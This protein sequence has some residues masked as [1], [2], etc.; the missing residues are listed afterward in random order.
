MFYRCLLITAALL[1]TLTLPAAASAGTHPDSRHASE[2]TE[3]LALQSADAYWSQRGRAA[4]PHPRIEYTSL[5]NRASA[6]AFVGPNLAAAYCV[7]RM[8]SRHTWRG[9]A[10]ALDFCWTIVHERGHQAGLEHASSGIMS[11]DGGDRPP[12]ACTRLFAKR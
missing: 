12:A 5:A 9:R 4:C 11:S 1:A 10:G 6:D 3:R 8:S 7:I 2:R